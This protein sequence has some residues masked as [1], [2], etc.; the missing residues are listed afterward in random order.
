MALAQQQQLA[1]AVRAKAARPAGV[2]LRPSARRAERVRA[3]AAAPAATERF[4]PRWRECY[5]YLR[6]K[7][8]QTIAPKEASKLVAGGEWVVV[9]VRRGDQHAKSHPQ[10]CVNIPLYRKLELFQGGFDAARVLKAIMYAFNGV[11]PI[12]ANPEF[13]REVAALAASGKGVIFA[14]EAGGTMKPSVNFSE[15]KASRSLQACYKALAQ[16]GASKVKHLERGVFGWY[17]AELPFTG[18]YTPEL[19]RF[20]SAASEPT[21]RGIA[22]ASGYE[23]RP[24]DKQ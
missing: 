8:L 2:V 5:E 15:G 3:A 7:G 12:E 9:D 20:P 21:L 10:G 6:G 4:I 11:D 18:P 1:R 24:E 22:S 13:V 23:T 19:G 14:C 16:A 17:Q